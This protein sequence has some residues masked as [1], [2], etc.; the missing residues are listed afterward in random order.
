MPAA[1]SNGNSGGLRER[2]AKSK[3]QQ[4]NGATSSS[5]LDT[6]ASNVSR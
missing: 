1:L 3:D 5:A 6:A 2:L 4:S